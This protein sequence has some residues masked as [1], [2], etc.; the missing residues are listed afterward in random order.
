MGR[1]N[2]VIYTGD[3]AFSLAKDHERVIETLKKKFTEFFGADHENGICSC[4]DA[5][6]YVYY[7]VFDDFDRALYNAPMDELEQVFGE[8]G[9]RHLGTVGAK[10]FIDLYM[11]Y[12]YVPGEKNDRAHYTARCMHLLTTI[13]QDD[14][15]A[16]VVFF[17]PKVLGPVMTHELLH[18]IS[19]R[20]VKTGE[21]EDQ[22]T[23][24]CGLALANRVTG[25]RD[26]VYLNEIFTQFLADKI[27]GELEEK[28]VK[29]GADYARERSFH[30]VLLPMF[31]DFFEKHLDVLKEA[32]IGQ[33]LQPLY[34]LFGKENFNRMNRNLNNICKLGLPNQYLDIYV[35][36]MHE[37]DPQDRSKKII[38]DGIKL[39]K[40]EYEWDI[41][42]DVFVRL[43]AL[44][45]E[46]AVNG[47]R[48][49]ESINDCLNHAEEVL[50][51]SSKK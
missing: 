10:Y 45:S 21:N 33:S 24:K 16:Q 23:E 1:I 31:E 14:V 35:Q 47:D 43:Q 38:Y 18:A 30:D 6:V 11:K 4:L 40:Q 3:S 2:D 29:F 50:E 19:M 51:S 32:Y 27:Y 37:Q 12:A 26:N 39:A 48:L 13:E 20:V 36:N 8:R 17:G 22:E 28:G 9:Y 41:T 25:Q 5:P 42:T 7:E 49:C 15:E 44:F 46:L 34:D